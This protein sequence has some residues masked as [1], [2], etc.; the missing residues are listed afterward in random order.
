VDVQLVRGTVYHVLKD[1]DRALTSFDR[2]LAKATE[3]EKPEIYRRRATTHYAM[4]SFQKSYEDARDG[5]STTVE[6]F[7]IDR[8]LLEKLM[9]DS[10]NQLDNNL[11]D[12]TASVQRYTAR[13]AEV[14]TLSVQTPSKR[15]IL[16]NIEKN[17]VRCRNRDK[18]Q[19]ER[20]TQVGI[21]EPSGPLPD[22][23]LKALGAAILCFFFMI[24]GFQA[25]AGVGFV[26]L[27]IDVA[28]AGYAAYQINKRSQ[29]RRQAESHRRAQ[30]RIGEIDQALHKNPAEPIWLK[31]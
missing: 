25:A 8:S 22:M 26:L 5:L 2:A 15:R 17:L 31:I 3:R 7:H 24:G 28:I 19:K 29:W 14:S 6:I 11:K 12:L 1:Y 13:K 10:I 9:S 21:K 30:E 16:E 20:A 4:R 27:L 23:P 18:L